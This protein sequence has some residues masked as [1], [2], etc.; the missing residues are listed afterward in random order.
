MY[1]LSSSRIIIKDCKKNQTNKK[2]KNNNNNNKNINKKRKTVSLKR[3]LLG[4]RR[5]TVYV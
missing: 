4:D 5:N 2:N 1:Q 3:Y